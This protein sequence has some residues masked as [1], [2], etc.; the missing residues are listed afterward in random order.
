MT[1]ADAEH[2]DAV[3]EPAYD[4]SV[5]VPVY[6]PG[7]L[8]AEQLR[9]LRRQDFDGTWEIVIADNGTTDGSLDDLSELVGGPPV[10]VV[11]ASA[12]RGPSHARNVG[13]QAAAGRCLAFCDADD[14]AAQGW[15]REL[16]AARDTGD[17]VA[18]VY[19][20]ER[21]NPSLLWAMRGPREHWDGLPQGP[22]GF[23]PFANTGNMMVRRDLYLSLGGFDESLT[24]CEDVEFSWRAQL[25]GLVLTLAPNAVIGY[26][27]RS[28]AAGTY[29]QMLSYTGAEPLLY[30]RYRAVGARRQS[31]ATV[32][33]RVWWVLSRSFYPLV[34]TR[35]RFLWC[36]IAGSV[37]GRVQGSLRHRVVYL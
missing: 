19:D 26:R 5:V 21:V 17:V 2:V 36:A 6:N 3:V 11:D 7:A 22:C 25:G 31:A 4:V 27:F 16:Y 32:V 8:L 10:R 18:G 33:G 34:D 14:V 20:V 13:A 9:A 28:T 23:L 29:R 15:L 30:L 35:R 1:P 24:S 37:I 12:R